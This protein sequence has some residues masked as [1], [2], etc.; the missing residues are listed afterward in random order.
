MIHRLEEHAAPE[1][2]FGVLIIA[3]RFANPFREYREQGMFDFFFWRIV[4]LINY[5][6]WYPRA[7]VPRSIAER[8]TMLPTF[9]PDYEVLFEQPVQKQPGSLASEDSDGGNASHSGDGG[10]AS[11][12]TSAI[13]YSSDTGSSTN[14]ALDSPLTQS[15]TA[16]SNQH[17]SPR[18]EDD[19][20]SSISSDDH[21]SPPAR[22]HQQPG[23]R[24]LTAEVPPC[25]ERLTVTWIGQ[26]C[27]FVQCN[28]IN[29]LTDPVFGNHLISAYI[30][31]KRIVPSPCS[32]DSLPPADF[33]LVSHNHPD[34]FEDETIRK[35]GNSAL[36]VVGLG[37]RP[38]LARRGIFKVVEMKWWDRISLPPIADKDM[39]GWEIACTPAMVSIIVLFFSYN[40]TK[41]NL[42]K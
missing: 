30:G 36:W 19:N 31:P 34:H 37:V 15:W 24:S 14:I 10:S 20:N 33:V 40:E 2:Q 25:A 1:K 3:G 13:Y 22:P 5:R 29:F 28:G 26:S 39:D 41:T 17:A 4:E 35:I 11:L 23:L 9:T 27:M 32:L 18:H 6:P 42:L 12:A 21:L 38:F 8:E 16:V 7:G